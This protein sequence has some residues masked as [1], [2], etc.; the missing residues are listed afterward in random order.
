MGPI[1]IDWYR[2]RGL[3]YIK[4]ETVLSDVISRMAG[5][6]IGETYEVEDVIQHYSA[7]R[8]DIYGLDENEYYNGMT[9]YGVAPMKGECWNLLTDW[10]DDLETEN[11]LSYEELIERFE[12]ETGHNIEWAE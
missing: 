7:G 3:T 2:K 6:K 8:I 4:K 10:L 5:R 11:L 12:T 9:E 1:N